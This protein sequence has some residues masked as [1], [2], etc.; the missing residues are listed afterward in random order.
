MATLTTNP[1]GTACVDMLGA[2]TAEAGYASRAYAESLAEFGAPVELPQC[3]GWLLAR[4]ISGRPALNDCM[5]CY[6]MFS[7]RDWR[8]VGEDLA[9][10]AN[11]PVCVSA[12]IDPF[13]DATPA[14]VLSAF[15]DVCY[16]YKQHFVTDLSQPLDR[17]M[18]S[19]HRRN[20][21]KALNAVDVYNATTDATTLA[22]WPALYANLIERHAI[23]GVARFSPL[24]LQRQI[25]V[26]GI[27]VFAASHVGALCGMTLWYVRGD[28]VYY[29]LAAYSAC[30]YEHGASFAL[31]WTALSHFARLGV[32]WAALGAGAG[33]TA[34]ES[35]LTR[36][37]QGWAT[38]TRTAYFCGRILQPAV[39]EQL[40]GH[41]PPRMNF[42]PAYRAAS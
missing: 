21:R 16:A 28:V 33:V 7:C 17:E 29:H 10:L 15:S 6:P 18:P 26:P 30:G 38:A 8:R 31:F 25:G 9:E 20:V 24:A 42:F 1:A 37:K 14:V 35:G 11:R 3:G 40:T 4:P 5:G 32:R 39:Y 22:Q 13:C 23:T 12:V 19:H 41:I 27:N 34:S 2:S 36:F